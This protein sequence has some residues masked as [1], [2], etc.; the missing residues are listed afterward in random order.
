MV[1]DVIELDDPG[2][3]RDKTCFGAAIL[4]AI[5]YSKCKYKLIIKEKT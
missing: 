3:K 1:F 2:K 5:F 4:D